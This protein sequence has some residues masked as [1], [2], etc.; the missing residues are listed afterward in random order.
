MELV[1]VWVVFRR[2]E[3]RTILA[4]VADCGI[5]DKGVETEWWLGH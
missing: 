3:I 1:S 4:C 5:V 2:L